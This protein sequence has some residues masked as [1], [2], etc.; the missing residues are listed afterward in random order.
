ME[1]R[2]NRNRRM[3]FASFLKALSIIFE[4]VQRGEIDV[5]NVRDLFSALSPIIS[6][7]ARM[8]RTED[9]KMRILCELAAS[10]QKFFPVG[11]IFMREISSLHQVTRTDTKEGRLLNF[12]NAAEA[13]FKAKN[14]SQCEATFRNCAIGCSDIFDLRKLRLISLLDQEMEPVS[15]IPE[16]LPQND[17]D[18]DEIQPAALNA[19]EETAENEG[20]KRNPGIYDLA[21]PAQVAEYQ[22]ILNASATVENCGRE[23]G[24]N[25]IL[26]GWQVA[27]QG[28]YP[29]IVRLSSGCG[30]TLV[31]DRWIVTA[32]H[33]VT[34]TSLVLTFLRISF[35]FCSKTVFPNPWSMEEM[36]PVSEIPEVLPQN[37][38]DVGEIQPAALNAL[39]ETAENE[40]KKRNP[41]IYDLA[42]P[43]QVAEYQTIL[44]AS[45]TVESCGG[46]LVSDRW[47]VTAAHC[48][49]MYTSPSQLSIKFRE[50]QLFAPDVGEFQ[51]QGKTIL[52]YST[53]YN[54][55][56]L[57][58]D[59]ALVELSVPVTI[60]GGSYI[61]PACLIAQGFDTNGF[62]GVPIGWGIYINGYGSQAPVLRE[63]RVSIINRN[64]CLK[65]GGVPSTTHICGYTKGAG[66]CYGDSG[67][68]LT[69]LSSGKH[70]F[71]G[72]TSGSFGD[73]Q[74][75]I[76]NTNV[77]QYFTQA[78][79]VFPTPGNTRGKV[80]LT[81]GLLQ[82]GE[83][84]AR[85]EPTNSQSSK[86][87][88]VPKKILALHVLRNAHKE[89][90]MNK[91]HN[92]PGNR[93]YEMK[94]VSEI[95]EVFSQNDLEVGEI[96]TAALN[97][98]EDTGENQEKQRNPGIYDLSD[99]A[100]V[101]EYQ[102]I[103]NASATVENCGR[104]NGGMNRIL[105]GWPVENQGFY[106]WIVR[107]SSGCGGT[108]VSDRW[109]VTAAHCIT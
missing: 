79:H 86:G 7:E 48:V 82:C 90:D 29:W 72:V 35:I 39:E 81:S 26:G 44:N 108:V 46:T 63:T 40:G 77:P 74:N 4:I 6:R 42:D 9:C 60:T 101:A 41:G 92:P 12:L 64:N 51:V 85:L 73:K 5:N 25:R 23:N 49:T 18:V 27:N 62:T 98:L 21:D 38:P 31:S 94:P 3:D 56:G 10:P 84:G 43:A 2:N 13:G 24:G 78:T 107:L 57:A 14:L 96:Q 93:A 8:I 69:V 16:V 37:D 47:I 11:E 17:H 71:A 28:Y 34:M 1:K 68:P 22:T 87:Y 89:K 65:A 53:L 59:I 103:L 83:L 91:M 102:T 30:G 33:C 95:P 67:G 55:S 106:P 76:C 109:I 100:Q 36:E 52:Y 15:E 66:I 20:K 70:Y 88:N 54:P 104:I 75:N 45:A 97:A 50:H 32:A 99:P 19:L 61:R 105:G 80:G 58:Y